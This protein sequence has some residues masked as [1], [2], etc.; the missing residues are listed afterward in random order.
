MDTVRKTIDYFPEQYSPRPQQTEAM[1]LIDAAFAS[2]KRVVS[3][4]MPTGGGKSFITQAFARRVRAEG[5]STH[6]L[7]IQKILQEQY[8]V[9][10][11]APEIEILKGRANYECT[12]AD[13]EEQYGKPMDA[14]NGVCKK[15]NKGILPDCIEPPYTPQDAV[16][17]EPPIEAHRCPYWKQLTKCIRSPITLFN[18]S[19]FLFQQ[20]IGRFGVRDLMVIDE[21]HNIEGQLMN[22][23]ELMLRE[24]DLDLIGVRIDKK[25]TTSEQL[26]MW[27]RE[28]EVMQRLA[29]RIGT[30]K[31][32]VPN[33]EDISED[34]AAAEH[35]ALQNLQMKLKNFFT[36]LEMTDWIVETQEKEFHGRK[37]KRLVCRPLYA[38]DFAHDLLFSKGKRILAVS[39]TIL[40]KRVWASNLGLKSDEV[41][42]IQMGTDFPK[43]KRPIHLEYVGS[44]NY[45]HKH[46]T[47]PKLIDWIKNVLLPR[48]EGERGI[49]HSHSFDILNAIRKGVPSDRFI[50]HESGQ[51]KRE[52]LALHAERPDSII[53]APAFHE[54]V[55]LKDDLSRFQVIAK[56][57]YPSTQDKIIGERLSRD[58]EW[59]GWVSALKL[60]QSYGRSVRSK[61]DYAVTYLIDEGF[62]FFR[63]RNS[64]LLPPWFKEALVKGAPKKWTEQAT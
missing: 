62:K 31:K 45:K 57:P 11:P 13:A 36:Y 29:D 18:F 20:R 15:L 40:S 12:H 4:E 17:F 54:G 56:V 19:S 1:N 50:F 43:E 41:E 30:E 48:H 9:D 39:A 51:D 28:K 59:Y 49:I 64:H 53:V 44:M 33:T 25:I 26:V 37:E 58:G 32:G 5:G 27:L 24:K 10:F 16:T 23:V 8:A 63:S 52:V 6:F 3:L 47:L 22:F 55:D 35:Q 61:T 34:L 7:T 21:A 42:F 38:K 2:G 14:A 60:V 46:K